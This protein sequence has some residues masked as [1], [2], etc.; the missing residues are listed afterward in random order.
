M[1]VKV[2][3]YLADGIVTGLGLRFENGLILRTPD[4]M[5]FL[6]KADKDALR[7]QLDEVIKEL[8][9]AGFEIDKSTYDE[10]R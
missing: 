8:E 10:N 5:T 3:V 6:P 7:Q 2:G 4:R 9:S 1:K